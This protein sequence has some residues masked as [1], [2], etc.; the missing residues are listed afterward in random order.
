MGGSFARGWGGDFRGSRRLFGGIPLIMA[1]GR[2]EHGFV[3][4]LRRR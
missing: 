2:L 3:R 4:L 1:L